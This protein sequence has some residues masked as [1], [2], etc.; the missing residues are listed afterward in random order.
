LQ[1]ET[2]YCI[3][4][5]GRWA[6][7]QQ[8]PE[9]PG[10]IELQQVQI[11]NREGSQITRTQREINLN[12]LN[13]ASNEKKLYSIFF[14]TSK[15]LG[16]QAKLESMGINELVLSTKFASQYS[17]DPSVGDYLY[18]E[19]A[20]LDEQDVLLSKLRQQ[21]NLASD[22]KIGMLAPYQI[23][24]T[25]EEPF[26]EYDI[27]GYSK[28]YQQGDNNFTYEEPPLISIDIWGVNQWAQ[29]LFGDVVDM[30]AS[31]GDVTRF[32]LPGYSR[33]VGGYIADPPELEAPTAPPLTEG[34]IY[35][36][37]VL[38][39]YQGAFCSECEQ[40][41]MD[42]PIPQQPV[43]NN[44][45]GMSF[46]VSNT[47]LPLMSGGFG[48]EPGQ[49]QTPGFMQSDYGL[50]NVTQNVISGTSGDKNV[51]SVTYRFNYDPGDGFNQT[52]NH[53]IN[54]AMGY[55]D[56][57]PEAFASFYSN[58]GQAYDMVNNELG[59][60]ASTEMGV[61][62]SFNGPANSSVNQNQ[63]NMN[64]GQLNMGF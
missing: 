3:Q 44:Q 45:S 27:N 30:L 54:K 14:R 63:L 1:P 18:L 20:D 64:M 48:E 17:E 35:D 51:M 56:P 15:Y 33:E 2:V 7:Q 28:S 6:A 31:S 60:V 22:D 5:I 46:G 9:Y 29:Q 41:R 36:G 8:G 39:Y 47:Y 34:E 13:L 42:N 52:P 55:T 32:A 50:G 57:A 11:F 62:A 58:M 10:V 4:F 19:S 59:S 43:G 49:D 23:C 61:S 16:Y 26:D 24:M 37:V 38:G 53:F 12:K 40:T 25:G 21:L